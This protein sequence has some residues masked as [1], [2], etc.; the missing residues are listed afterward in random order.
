MY[1]EVNTSRSMNISES[2]LL[3]KAIALFVIM[4][5][6]FSLFPTQLIYAQSGL[7]QNIDILDEDDGA[8]AIEEEIEIEETEE[9]ETQE[10]EVAQE[11]PAQEEEVDE[12][13]EEEPIQEEDVE[14]TT[15]QE[16]VQPEAPAEETQQQ[17]E[18]Q[19]PTQEEDVEETQQ[20][21]A[22]QQEETQQEDETQQEEATPQSSQPEE[23]EVGGSDENPNIA[24]D[25]TGALTISFAD[26]NDSGQSTSDS[27]TN[28]GNPRFDVDAPSLFGGVANARVYTFYQAKSSNCSYPTP[29][30]SAVSGWT[31]KWSSA[32]LKGF[33]H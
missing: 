8:S 1:N 14:E 20:Q 31:S 5:L 3:S 2:F 30:T 12:T 33:V 29:S 21:P 11:E 19:Q 18:E 23:V 13:Q 15:Q 26:G 6:V 27:I 17:Q 4:S 28:L 25:L 32:R 9:P 7:T 16:P 22:P 10:E 24:T